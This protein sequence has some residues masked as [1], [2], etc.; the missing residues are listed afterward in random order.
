MLFL[1]ILNVYGDTDKYKIFDIIRYDLLL[2]APPHPST[3]VD[4]YHTIG[5]SV[6]TI[7][8]TFTGLGS[9]GKPMVK[10]NYDCNFDELGRIESFLSKTNE[11]LVKDRTTLEYDE[12]GLL[13]RVLTYWGS[14]ISLQRSFKISYEQLSETSWRVDILRD[15]D[16]KI[17]ESNILEYFPDAKVLTRDITGM[18][19]IQKLI[20]KFDPKGRIVEIVREKDS[21]EVVPLEGFVYGENERIMRYLYRDRFVETFSYQGHSLINC[22]RKYADNRST[23]I[24]RVLES[25]HKGNWLRLEIFFKS[26][27]KE[28]TMWFDRQITYY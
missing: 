6:K 20:Y 9:N 22:E 3:P 7:Q 13:S 17:Y 27:T 26:K 8:I 5:G 4:R 24:Y 11:T 19:Y 12:N 15:S 16:S 10:G 2:V 23:T 28:D 1:N 14:K 25:D 18:V 21:G